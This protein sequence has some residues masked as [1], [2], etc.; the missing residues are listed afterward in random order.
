MPSLDRIILGTLAVAS[1]D[2]TGAYISQRGFTADPPVHNGAGDNTLALTDGLDLENDGTVT[3][4]S[5]RNGPAFIAVEYLTTTSFRVRT[6]ALTIAGTI[7][8][9]ATNVDFWVQI[10]EI[11]PT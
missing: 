7:T 9:L 2:G 3:V 6:A 8:I 5:N 11:A 4:G 1:V 10:D